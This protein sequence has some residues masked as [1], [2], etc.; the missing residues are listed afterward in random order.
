MT[1]TAFET[2]RPIAP[3]GIV[4]R[5]VSAVFA[6]EADSAATVARLALGLMIL[7]HGLQKAFG[8]FGGYGFEGTMG[9]MTGTLGI[10]GSP[11]D[12]G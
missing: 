6:T 11:A 8:L 3:T 9:F 10:P 4:R 7:P 1:S 2:T 5:A 12:S